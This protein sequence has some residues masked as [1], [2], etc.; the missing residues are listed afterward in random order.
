MTYD[1]AYSP[2]QA[3]FGPTPM[4]ASH[5][6]LAAPHAEEFI[7][8]PGAPDRRARK[9]FLGAVFWAVSIV[10]GFSALLGLEILGE[11]G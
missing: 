2:S 10:L 1:Y 8:E 3:T 5:P 9:R 11:V 4:N 7:G 6:L